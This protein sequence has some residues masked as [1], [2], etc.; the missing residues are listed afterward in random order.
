MSVHKSVALPRILYESNMGELAMLTVWFAIDGH[1]QEEEPSAFINTDDLFLGLQTALNDYWFEEIP[2]KV[3]SRR[4]RV[5]VGD[6]IQYEE[7]LFQITETGL[8]KVFERE[9]FPHVGVVNDPAIG[10][11]FFEFPTLDLD[12]EES[13]FV[14]RRSMKNPFFYIETRKWPDGQEHRFYLHYK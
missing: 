1:N 9:P 8:T 4:R 14:S 2:C 13:E 12:W 5:G 10:D 7:Q 11:A 3:I 6:F